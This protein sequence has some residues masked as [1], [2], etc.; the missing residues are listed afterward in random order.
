[1]YLFYIHIYI[2]FLQDTFFDAEDGSSR[3]MKMSLLTIDRTPIPSHEWLQFDS[4][5]QEFYGVPMRTDIGRKEY[6]LVVTDKDGK[7]YHTILFS[8]I[9]KIIFVYIE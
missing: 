1:M 9:K 5:N 8:K 7:F 6:Q 2:F 3:N 4:K